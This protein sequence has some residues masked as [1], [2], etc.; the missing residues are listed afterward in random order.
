MIIKRHTL[1]CY[2]SL[3]TLSDGFPPSS[4][5]KIDILQ[6]RNLNS[7]SNVLGTAEHQLF[8]LAGS[9]ISIEGAQPLLHDSKLAWHDTCIA[10]HVNSC[11]SHR[12]QVVAFVLRCFLNGTLNH[13]VLMLF[14]APFA[15]R[16]MQE[17]HLSLF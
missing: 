17:K 15:P 7:Q 10:C 8:L 14:S 4:L 16:I 5:L 3:L 1:L 11:H 9:S 13:S 6:L 2:K 12:E